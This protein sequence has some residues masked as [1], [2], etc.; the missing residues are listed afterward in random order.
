MKKKEEFSIERE[1]RFDDDDEGMGADQRRATH[2][3]NK[4]SD[5]MERRLY[6]TLIS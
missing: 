3:H 5:R 6:S 2:T 4:E 1:T